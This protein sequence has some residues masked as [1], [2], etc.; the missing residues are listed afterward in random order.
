MYLVYRQN[1]QLELKGWPN[2]EG[3]KDM[4][5][6]A[7]YFFNITKEEHLMQKIVDEG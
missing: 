6:Q 4:L 2:K 7:I 5:K 1:T 3:M